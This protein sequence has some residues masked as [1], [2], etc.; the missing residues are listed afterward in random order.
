MGEESDRGAVAGRRCASSGTGRSSASRRR[1]AR[2]HGPGAL[3]RRRA[4]AAGRAASR[5]TTRRRRCAATIPTGWT[6]RWSGCSARRAPP[7]AT[8]LA[9]RAPVDLRVNTLKTDVGARAE[10]A[11]AVRRR[12]GRRCCPT[13]SASPR[14]AAS[15]RAAPVE[16]APEFEKGWFEVQDLGSQ[17]AAAARR[18]DR[19]ASRCSTSAPA[20]AARPWR[21]PRRWAT[22]ASSTPTT[23]TRAGSPRPC[24]APS[25]PGVRN[26]QVRSPI[27]PNALDGLE[28]RMDLVF[29]DAPCTGS[30]TWRR[31]PD[32]KWRLTPAAARAPHGRAGR[33]A[34][35]RRRR[36]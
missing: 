21:W 12:A 30:G 35:R 1:P 25:G 31:H 14:P 23:P 9:A 4:R 24:A 3:T 32:A 20:A 11:G 29:V 15:E 10:G 13:R 33:G 5:S 22:P 2:P 16:A 26:L 18:R 6:R 34:G 17:I 27:D 19:A 8:A 36:S 28:G 7:R